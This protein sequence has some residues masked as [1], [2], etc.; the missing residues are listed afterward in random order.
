[1]PGTNKNIWETGSKQV[2]NEALFSRLATLLPAL[3]L[4]G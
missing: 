4:F 3:V 1:M 2:L